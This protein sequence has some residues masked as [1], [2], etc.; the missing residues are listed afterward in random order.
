[1]SDCD[2]SEL[3][4]LVNLIKGMANRWVYESRLASSGASPELLWREPHVP[5]D[6]PV[7]VRCFGGVNEVGVPRAG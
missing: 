7:A 2:A 6:H 5:C 4:R 3:A 1:M